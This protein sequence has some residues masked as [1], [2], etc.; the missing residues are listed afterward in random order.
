ME[1]GAVMVIIAEYVP[2]GLHWPGILL[3]LVLAWY[4]LTELG[5]V[6]ENAVKMGAS[7]P[8]WLV[9]MLKASVELTVIAGEKTVQTEE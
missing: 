5:S 2:I 6:L 4:I 3:P 7:V 1:P 9:K 8:E